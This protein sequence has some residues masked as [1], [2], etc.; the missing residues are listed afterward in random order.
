MV[1]ALVLDLDDTLVTY[2]PGAD[3]AWLAL[4]PPEV[5]REQL[6]AAFKQA[7]RWL[8][9]TP[10]Q[11]RRTRVDAWGSYATVFQ[12]TFAGCQHPIPDSLAAGMAD[13]FL[14]H[15]VAHLQLLPGSRETLARWKAAGL[16]LA[17]VT[18]GDARMQRQKLARFDLAGFFDAL[19]FESESPFGKPD[20]E[21]YR[22]ALDQ[23]GAAAQEAWMI[24]DN[25]EFDV[26]GPQR[27]GLKAAW[28]DRHGKGLPPKASVRPDA[29]LGSLVDWA[30]T[31]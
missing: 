14:A 10:E 5:A 29:I 27:A 28:L 9:E 1:K 31:A 26:A 18:N 13:A 25:L 4:A 8:W 30:P 19:V 24:G 17:L 2:G 11:H 12:K 21:I 22:I 16:R 20:P 15:L 3:E 23:L 6:E 7:R